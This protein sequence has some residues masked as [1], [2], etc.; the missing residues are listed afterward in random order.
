MYMVALQL[1]TEA[2]E[3]DGNKDDLFANR[4]QAYIKLE[5]FAGQYLNPIRA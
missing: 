2:I 1:Y 4:A 5:I 3:A